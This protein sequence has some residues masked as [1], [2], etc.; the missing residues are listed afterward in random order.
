[1]KKIDFKKI[2]IFE[3]LKKTW[4]Y[5]KSQ[6]G[7]LIL[8][9][10]GSLI[11]SVMGAIT[12]ILAA[13]QILKLS[14]NLLQEL[15]Y[16]SL[17]IF[18]VEIV[19]NIVI[20]I[21]NKANQTFFRETSILIKSDMAKQMLKFEAK[22]IDNNSSGVFIDRISKDTGYIADVFN[23]INDSVADIIANIGIL[24]A[25]FIVSK[26]MFLFFIFSLTILFFFKKARMRYWF[27]IDK[28]Y[29][30][31]NEKN[32]GLISELIRGIRDV[33]L[34][35]AGVGIT[36]RMNDRFVESNQKQYEMGKVDRKYNFFSNSVQGL[37]DITFIGLGITL[38]S[39]DMLSVASFVVLY[40]YKDKIYGLLDYV[41]RFIEIIKK[42]NVSAKR[43]FELLDD[44][45]YPKEKFGTTHLDKVYGNFEFRNVKFEYK[46]NIPVLKD[47]N[48]KINPNETVAFIGKSGS[49]KS[50]IFSLITK[51]YNPQSGEIL[52]ENINI[53]ELD[54]DS[55]RGNITV[56]TQSP[57]IFNFS[58]K[59]NLKIVDENLTDEQIYEACK[60][61]CLH[62]FIMGL[63]DK[64]DTLVGEG[65]VMLSGGERQRLAI[66]RALLKKSEIIL[67]D[68]ATSALDNQTQ[69]DI[70]DAIN[71][72]KGTYTIL[73]IAHR[74]STV[75]NSDRILLIDDGK[76]VAEGTHKDLYATNELYRNL[77]E[78][79]LT[80]FD[81][82]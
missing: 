74:L 57:Y 52:I 10:I 16:I 23:E 80:E 40:M 50:T 4:Q 45:I 51:L 77:Y 8:Y 31:L 21:A 69:K 29:R 47:V 14:N 15:F 13:Q 18:G 36:K 71:N 39:K 76:I 66:A 6:K 78:K 32:T 35:H 63:P 11:L 62:D 41:S 24:V 1:M 60:S 19:R 7:M 17:V 25:I 79:E 68:E 70:Q 64:Y 27:E 9:F 3:N 59:E 22:V 12:P 46:E 2:E 65:G 5:S 20:V 42:F 34:L 56:I 67:F 33:K 26:Y 75:I 38:A 54:E 49:G 82:N 55:I 48:F 81:T 30:K 61:A 44:S 73:I 53:G 43:V 28:E 72:M 58:I 37:M